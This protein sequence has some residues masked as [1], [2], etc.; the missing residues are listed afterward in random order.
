[1][2]NSLERIF[3][4]IEKQMEALNE[5]MKQLLLSKSAY[6]E[7]ISNYLSAQRGKQL[8]PAMVF[9]SAGINGAINQKSVDCATI[10]EFVHL[11]SLVHDDVIDVGLQRHGHPTLNVVYNNKT[12]VLAGDFLLARC[13]QK[14]IQMQDF[15]ILQ[16]IADTFETM[17]KAELTHLQC[18]TITCSEEN[19]LNIVKAKTAKLI[20]TCFV[21]GSISVN[22][23][24]NLLPKW[25]Q[26]GFNV[27]V[28]FQLKDDLFDYMPENQSH[29][30]V[31]KDINEHKITLPLI[32]TLKNMEQ[33][34]KEELL[35]FYLHHSGT[36]AECKE[37]V[38]TV[39]DNGGIEYVNQLIDNYLNPCFEFIAIQKDSP[40]KD[41]LQ[42]LFNFLKNRNF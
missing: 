26:I 13:L 37:I 25:R 33:Y 38:K 1:M 31:F 23:P 18:T 8:R 36:E 17:V 3:Y 29:K 10:T 19:Y 14:I 7:D 27:G 16:M 34:Q 32:A 21:L 41:A 20:E 6:I 2:T 24:P 42:N 28:A 30:D 5:Q 39:S 12:A 11:S 22:C 15:Q 40:Y 35:D 4:P 9:L